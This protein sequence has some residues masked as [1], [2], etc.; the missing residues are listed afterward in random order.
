MRIPDT[1]ASIGNII[2]IPIYADSTLT[3]KGIISYLLQINYN[4]NCLQPVSVISSNTISASFGSPVANMNITGTITISG[5]GVSALAG[6]GK[7]IYLRF[8]VI[9]SGWCSLNFTGNTNNFFNEGSPVMSFVNGSVNI[10]SPPGIT[11]SPDNAIIT[12]GEQ[13][14][15]SA[16]GGTLPYQWFVT[17]SNIASINSSGLLTANQHGNTKVVV[18]SNNGL[19]D[20]TNIIEIRPMKLS[21]PSNLSQWQGN[22]ILIPVNTTDLSSLNILS[23]NFKITYNPNILTPI[24]VIKTGTLMASFSNPTYY[25]TSGSISLAFYNTTAIT[26]SGTL[27]YIKFHVSNQNTGA[28]SLTISDGLFNQDLYPNYTNGYFT[29]INFPT[30]AISP[31]SGSLVAGETQQFS[32]SGGGIPPL[33]WSVTDTIIASINSSGLLTAKRSGIVKVKVIDS[34][35]ATAMSSNFQLYDTRIIMPDTIYCPSNSVFYYPI[36]IN[37]LPN[38]QSIYSFQGS[39]TYNTSLLTFTSIETTGSLTQGW[40]YITNSVNG[41][42][43]FMGYGTNQFSSQGTIVFLKFTANPSFTLGSNASISLNNV[44]LNE[45][46][47]LPMVDVNGYIIGALPGGAGYIS[48]ASPVC[49]GQNNIIYSIPEIANSTNYIWT[50]PNGATGNS[51]S[52]IISV[53]YGFSAISGDI[54]VKG[55]NSCGI[56]SISSRAIT[57]NNSPSSPT[58][59]VQNNCGNSVLT[60]INYTGTLNWSTG[61]STSSIT[62]STTGIYSVNQTVGG[63]TSVNGSGTA[64]PIPV[65]NQTIGIAV[66]ANPVDAG[67]SVTFTATLNNTVSGQ[68]FE[69]YVNNILKTTTTSLSYSFIPVN[70]DVIKCIALPTNCYSGDTSNN[71]TMTVNTPIVPYPAGA[72]TGSNTVCKGQTGVLYSIPLISNATSY[73]W[74]LPSG[75]TGNSSTNSI[76]V[77]FGI[78]AVSDS[79]KVRGHNSIGDGLYSSLKITVSTLPATVGSITGL[80]TVCQGQNSV[81]YK[82]PTVANATSYTWT[83]PTGAIGTSTIDSIIVSFGT[84]AVS[85]NITVKGNNTCGSGAV[86]SKAIT[87]N[88]LPATAGTITGLATVCQG[89]NSVVYKV[90][91]VANATSYTWT[92][93]TG[94]SGTSTID[95]IIVSFGTSAVSGNVTVK[96]NNTCGSGT[97]STKAITVNPLPATAGTITGLAIVCQGQINLTYKVPTIANATSYTWSLPSGASGTST[98]DSIIVSFGTSAASGNITVKGNNTCGSGAVSTKA[99]TINPL[100][101]TAGT[102]TGLATVCQGQNSVVYKVPTVANTTSYTW[103]L[104]TG[105][106]GTSTIDSIIVSYG[107]SAVA[108]NV[109]VKGNNA[110]GSGAV[111]TKAITVNPLPAT[112]GTITGLATVCQGQSSV[113]YKVPTVTN[114]TSYTWTLPSGASGTSTIDS[115]IV[116]FGT[117]AVSG[118][119]TVKGNN[120][121][122]SGAVS[123]KAITVNPLPAT[124]G[125]I[126]GL[127]TVCQGQNSVIYKVPTVA[128]TTSYTWTLPT[129][130]SGTSTIDSIIVNYGTSAVSGNVTVKG[131]N[132]CGSGTVS[133]KAITVNPLPATAGTITGLATVCQGQNS[134]VYKVPIIANTTSYTWTL[135]TGASGTSNVDSIVVSYGTS[136]VSGN[137]T[138]KGNN[139]CGSG[140]VSTKAITVNPLPANA[141]TITGLAIVCQGQNSVVY[142]VPIVTNTT[143]YTWT[144]PTGVSGTSI[145]DSVV[146]N[147]GTSAV[148]GNMTVKGN[149]SC[150]SGTVST[151]AITVNPLPVVG[152]QTSSIISGSAFTITP[153]GVPTATTYTWSAPVYTNGVSGGSAQATGQLSISQI[154]TIPAGTGTATYTVTPKSGSCNGNTFTVI[155]TV[156]N[157]CLLSW[158]PVQN[159]QYNMSV[160]A[161][162]YLSNLITTNRID[163]IGAFVGQECR[164]IAYPDT[165][166]NGKLF[167]TISSNAQSGETITFKAWRSSLCDE[168]PVFETLPFISQSNI[169]S[170]SNPV[171]FHCGNIELC[172]NF[173]AGY[174]WFSV[175][176]NPGSMNL[177]SL[178]NNL[179]PCENDRIIGQQSFATY[180]GNQW[181]GSLSTI[182]PK[183]MY[184]MKLCSLQSWC[185]QG[186]PVTIQ[187]ITIASG[188]P[189]IGY[190]PQVNLPINTALANISPVPVSNDRIKGQYS[191]ATFSGTQW[192]GSLTSMQKGKGYII[193]LT[194]PSVLNYASNL[195]KS[196][197]SFDELQAQTANPTSDNVKTNARYNLQIIAD[198]ILPD[199]NISL[200]TS[201]KVYA[202]VGNECRGVSSPF[203]GLNGKLF[204]TV[205]SDIEQGEVIHFKV[206]VSSLNQLFDVNNNLVFSSEMETGTM[207]NPYQFDL[208]GSVGISLDNNQNEISFG[209]IYPNPFDK[210]ASLDFNIYNAGKVEGKII[211]GLGVEVQTIVS[212]DFEAGSYILKIDAEN[213]TPGI[214]SLLISYSNKE[215]SSVITK[216][217]IIK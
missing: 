172:N 45:G 164:G 141:G 213:L 63:C 50:L 51:N 102:I 151:K 182:D 38:G 163:A 138:V 48:G 28:S 155:V 173:G 42:L 82:V 103:T 90:P 122:G 18:Q 152:N 95:S 197:I 23:G 58:V 34:I 70:G 55:T 43:N 204:L 24:E 49:K 33:T 130:A 191:F 181:V 118:N 170:L 212:K 193:Q 109:T 3:G 131:N 105:T 158:I 207:G 201:D 174:T 120:S 16:S 153:T 71:I 30:L 214:Y 62:V 192:V 149:N 121:C 2:D 44:L 179:T 106:S 203:S 108:G 69:W 119:I 142:K 91:T 160:I 157:S 165:T 113:V 116:S 196:A 66:G 114:A 8:N 41:Q 117:S 137:V 127:A 1:T 166:Q 53:N 128:N 56:G 133:S 5:Y 52:N 54:T 93:P 27:I 161:N 185:K 6:S 60:A 26:G 200:N 59:S 135:P 125:T 96:G 210:T 10:P 144:L 80:A 12:K 171:D 104:P 92:L 46:I 89:Q 79:I 13:L 217:M 74:T 129:G 110:C 21:I 209:D 101:A 88:P 77:D 176:I 97:V 177:N 7:F 94:T 156:V 67:I 162:L 64:S 139:A 14:Q 145:V 178:F 124:A 175:N 148:S 111:S 169:G 159:Q 65:V 73:I 189:W 100:P 87:V 123:T 168:C 205:G 20:T 98:I 81:V 167:L 75:A 17:N 37:A 180:F 76:L 84:S 140:I 199:G 202:Y 188:Y 143:S 216:K 206:Y 190:L 25:I 85:G 186:L 72:I 4:P 32:V 195:Q 39:L 126:T 132:A 15:F 57:V 150:G 194:N 115:I 112:A 9:Q 107:T 35:G 11:A 198:I 134:V 136:A 29:T 215:N 184:K 154:L 99:I 183:A 83:L 36:K 31:N 146:V 61:A 47:P 208:T 19:K 147:Y 187:P 211:N 40:N 22:D 68:N 78:N 86:S